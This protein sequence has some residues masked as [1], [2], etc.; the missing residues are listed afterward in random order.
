MDKLTLREFDSLCRPPVQPLNPEEI[1]HIREASN[2]SQAVFASLLNISPST[3]QKWEIGKK[4]PTG[5]AL[6]L[7]HLV[8]KRGLSFVAW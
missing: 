5:A 4:K 8:H 3:V 6:K 1:R 7:L 2:V